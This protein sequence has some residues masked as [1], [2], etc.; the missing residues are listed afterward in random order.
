MFPIQNVMKQDALMPLLFKSAFEY[1][2]RKVQV[3]QVGMKLSETHPLL[4]YAD[5]VLFKSVS[6]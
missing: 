1:T 2:I 3:N 6:G 4:V 5:A